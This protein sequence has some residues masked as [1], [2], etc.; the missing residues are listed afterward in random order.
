MNYI[1]SLYPTGT[2]IILMGHSMGGIV[3]L[4]LLPAGEKVSSVITMSTPHSIPPAR[5]D[6][7]MDDIYSKVRE[8][9]ENNPTPILS[10]CGGITDTMIPSEFC[11]LPEAHSANVFRKTVFSS[12]LEGCWTGVGHREMVWCHQVRWRIARAA[13]EL[14]TAETTDEMGL[15]LAKWF[16]DGSSFPIS[17]VIEEHKSGDFISH[18]IPDGQPLVLREPMDGQAYDFLLSEKQDGQLPL[19]FVAY[20]SRGSILSV[21]P[22]NALPL[23]VS[24]F[25]C[26]RK[27]RVTS[28]DESELA[29]CGLLTPSSL[30]LIPNPVPGELFPLPHE[31]IDESE[32][33]VMFKAIIP[34]E[35]PSSQD[36]WVSL[37]VQNEGREGWVIASIE[38][39]HQYISHAGA[40]S[41]LILIYCNPFPD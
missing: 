30:K 37:R 4:S 19:T 6:A 10:I 28:S 2:K 7:R 39:Q 29:S 25:Y 21:A 12:G 18:T 26:R 31:G 17:S 9:L 5:F 38:N 14:G 20:V 24:M 33:V 11:T 36:E 16:E 27:V 13:L 41:T 22:F 15:I 40:F 34:V 32:G 3:G 1:L 23:K 35:R 8:Q